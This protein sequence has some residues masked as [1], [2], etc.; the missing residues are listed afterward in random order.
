MNKLVLGTLPIEEAK[1]IQD[2]MKGKSVDI[3]LDHNPTT[4]TRG[5]SVTVE[6]SCYEKD[7]QQV[8]Q[9]FQQNFLNSLD[10]HNVNLE[11]LNSTY[12]PN[13]ESATCPA[14]GTSFSTSSTECPE[15]GLCFG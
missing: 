14:C 6:F 13:Q 11:L 9:Y 12:D 5:C 7:I 2:E 4:C 8:A 15:C 3:F 1:K 10:G